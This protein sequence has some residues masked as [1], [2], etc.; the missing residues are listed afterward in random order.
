[1]NAAPSTVIAIWPDRSWCY[2]GAI[3]DNLGW[4]SDA[5]ILRSVPEDWSYEAIEKFVYTQ[6]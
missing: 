4:I 3:E 6:V 1:M 5:F 2:E